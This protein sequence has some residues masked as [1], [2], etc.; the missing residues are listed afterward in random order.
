MYQPLS[1]NDRTVFKWKSWVT[2]NR[3]EKGEI[4]G[5]PKNTEVSK[6][7]R[8]TIK[9]NKSV[10][11]LFGERKQLLFKE[12]PYPAPKKERNITIGIPRVLFLLGYN[13]VLDNV[14]QN[15]RIQCTVV[16]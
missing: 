8:E 5:D 11:D 12:Y 15:V 9:K 7:L 4:I 10:P 1:E 16:R 14:F 2:N 6:K 3:C 13:A